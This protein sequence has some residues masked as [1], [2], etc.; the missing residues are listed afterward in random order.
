MFSVFGDTEPFV[1]LVDVPFAVGDDEPPH[2][3]AI[4]RMARS[5]PR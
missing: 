4:N 1:V 5:K 2:A 3:D